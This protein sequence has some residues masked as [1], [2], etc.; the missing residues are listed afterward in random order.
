MMKLEFHV[1]LREPWDVGCHDD[2]T[3]TVL[4]DTV[5]LY[6]SSLLQEHYSSSL[7]VTYG[8]KPESETLEEIQEAE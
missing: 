4:Y 8:I 3:A 6:F 7:H 1:R 2:I 5:L